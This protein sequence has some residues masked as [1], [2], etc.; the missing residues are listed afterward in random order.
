MTAPRRAELAAELER[1]GS[2]YPVTEARA[3][4]AA[5]ERHWAEAA[6]LYARAARARPGDARLVANAAFC[7]ARA[8]QVDAQRRPGRA[9]PL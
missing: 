1:L 5:S 2:D 7:E 9:S 8:Q 3:A 6:R 4:R